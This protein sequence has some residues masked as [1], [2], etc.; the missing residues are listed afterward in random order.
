MN[1]ILST[2]MPIS[3][4]I[5]RN[6]QPIDIKNILKFF[7]IAI[8][9]FGVFMLGTGVYAICNNQGKK[10]EKNL[11]PT[12][13]IEN[14]TETSILLKVMHQMNI[15]KVEYRWNDEEKITVNGNNG[16]YLE[17]EINIPSGTNTLHV[18]VIDE[19]GKEITYEK[20]YELESNINFEVAGNKIK[21]TYDGDKQVSYMKY[22]WDD[23]EETRV[24]INGTSIEQ[25]IEA[26]KGLHELTVVVVDEDDNIDT[27][28][29]KINGVSKP[30][31][32]ISIDEQGTHFIIKA[33]DDDQLSKIHFRLNQDDTK[34]YGLNLEDMNMK[35]LEYVLPMELQS[36]ENII[37]VTV[38]NINGIT[39]ERG[40]RVVK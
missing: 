37:E 11:E 10:Q 16:K 32:E 17:K 25:E 18:L 35:D 9:V 21:I 7:A 28:V 6:K 40:A 5:N 4:R 13:S 3:D 20:S 34:V 26:I 38:Y 29:Q 19:N 12:I 14:K 24:D 39:E 30:K 8:L 27:K 1:Q 22:R 31:L 15:D 36:G 33:S 2:S 23:G